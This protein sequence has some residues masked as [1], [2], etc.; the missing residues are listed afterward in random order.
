[1][2]RIYLHT[3]YESAHN[4]IKGIFFFF[5]HIFLG[6]KRSARGPYGPTVCEYQS[7]I[8]IYM[9]THIGILVVALYI[10]IIHEVMPGQ[11]KSHTTDVRPAQNVYNIRSASGACASDFFFSFLFRA[12]FSDEISDARPPRPTH[13]N[14]IV[15][16]H[17]A[18]NDTR[19]TPRLC[20]SSA[21]VCCSL[22]DYIYK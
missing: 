13:N 10:C 9:Y 21:P 6:D 20:C 19:T 1:M 14:I 11:Q 22:H 8:Y 4:V 17:P 7:C 2:R 3:H 15:C 5:L 16:A 18:N 12:L